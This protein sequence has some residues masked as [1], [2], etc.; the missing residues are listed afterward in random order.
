M[1]ELLCV[2]AVAAVWIIIVISKRLGLLPSLFASNW[3]RALESLPVPSDV[4][5]RSGWETSRFRDR[6]GTWALDCGVSYTENGVLVREFHPQL[7]WGVI[8][9]HRTMFIPWSACSNPRQ[10]W[11]D[12][13]YFL[14]RDRRLVELDVAGQEFSIFVDPRMIPDTSSLKIE[15]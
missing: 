10:P 3:S 4:G 2:A 13:W 12:R 11:K 1:A 6:P 9:K 8:P 7:L 14:C 5:E 15:L